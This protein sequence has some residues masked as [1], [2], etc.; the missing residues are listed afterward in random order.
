M[1]WFLYDNGLRHE[2]VNVSFLFFHCK[3]AAMHSLLRLIIK[4]SAIVMY[5]TQSQESGWRAATLFKK[6][7]PTQVFSCEFN[8]ICKNTFFIGHLSWLLL[9]IA[10]F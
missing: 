6:E 7:T 10:I 8:K 3:F 5:H 4:I 9:N 1:D 2:R